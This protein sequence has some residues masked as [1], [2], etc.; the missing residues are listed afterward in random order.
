M[1]RE[2]L[3]ASV[4]FAKIQRSETGPLEIRVL[5]E[6]PGFETRATPHQLL[7]YRNRLAVSANKALEKKER[8][9][10]VDRPLIRVSAQFLVAGFQRPWHSFSGVLSPAS[11]SFSSVLVCCFADALYCG[12]KK[13]SSNNSEN[14]GRD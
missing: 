3:A 13:Q 2:S 9:G 12:L 10:P 1:A 14:G 7:L 5:F 11:R 6:P 8:V 4:E